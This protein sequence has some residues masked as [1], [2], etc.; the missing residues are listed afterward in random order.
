MSFEK[1]NYEETVAAG[2]NASGLRRTAPQ[3]GPVADVKAALE[4]AGTLCS[5][6]EALA[7]ALVGSAPET[8]GA[9]SGVSLPNGLFDELASKARYLDQRVSDAERALERIEKVAL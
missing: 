6:V 9:N 2:R 4:R 1:M 3:S 7:D 5:R 8:A